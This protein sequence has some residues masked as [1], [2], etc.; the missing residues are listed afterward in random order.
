M[1]PLIFS[2]ALLLTPLWL[3]GPVKTTALAG[4]PPVKAEPLSE[5]DRYELCL[6][7]PYLYECSN[8]QVPIALNERPGE[9]GAC[10]LTVNHVDSRTIC[11]LVI[12][13]ETITAYQEV[14]EPLKVL[15]GKKASREIT[16]SP[17]AIKAIRYR[18]TKK[19][20]TTGRVVQGLV[21]GV[22]GLFG[23]GSKK[24]SELAIDYTTPPQAA[25]AP[26]GLTPKTELPQLETSSGAGMPTAMPEAGMTTLVVVVRRKTGEALRMQLEQLTG[27]KAEVP[28]VEKQP[29]PEN[30]PSEPQ[31][32]E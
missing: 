4:L 11:K 1:K 12:N 17:S 26:E 5:N 28:Q 19:D 30:K 21:F 18:L 27:L 15:G 29:E 3:A 24:V 7:A 16:L 8:S 10:V 6:K 20:N 25:S 13:K 31:P 2:I 22:F 9:A 14:G 32:P 23:S